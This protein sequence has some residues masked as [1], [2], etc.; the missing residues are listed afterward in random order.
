MKW[1]HFV[2]ASFLLSLFFLSVCTVDAISDIACLRPKDVT[3]YKKYWQ[4][5]SWNQGDIHLWK[6]YYDDRRSENYVR[7]IA[8][9]TK[10]VKPN[11]FCYLWFQSI[12]RQFEGRQAYKRYYSG[13][14]THHRMEEKLGTP[15]PRLYTLRLD[16]LSHSKLWRR[17]P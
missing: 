11:I 4:R 9:A 12:G 13:W 8:M 14:E 3:L 16:Q 2:L 1:R 17:C 6:A 15:T 7:I 5:L 10:K